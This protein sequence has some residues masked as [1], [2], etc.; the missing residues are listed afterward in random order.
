MAAEPFDELRRSL[1]ATQE[2]A[3]RIAGRVPAQ[4]WAS[5]TERNVAAA[6]IEALVT[7]LRSLRGVVPEEVWDEVR[8]LA[9]LL[10]LLL[11]AILDAIVQR[12]TT[13]A[14]APSD[15]PGPA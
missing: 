6:E 5:E 15:G 13:D 14:P 11:R 8:E 12:L 10:V 7:V 9:R 3:E 1:R 2:A 4:G